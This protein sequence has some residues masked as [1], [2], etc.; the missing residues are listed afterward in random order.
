MRVP[1]SV[2]NMATVA[3]SIKRPCSTTPGIEL[4]TRDRTSG[5]G[6]LPECTVENEVSTVRQKWPSAL[7]CAE[8]DV[9]VTTG[10]TR[11]SRDLARRGRGSERNH[12]NRKCETAPAVSTSLLS[13]AI[14][15]M[16]LELDATIFS[17]K[18]APPPPLIRRREA[19]SSSAPSTVTSRTGVSSSVVSG[20]PRERASLLGCLRCRHADHLKPFGHAR[21]QSAR[22]SGRLWTRFP[23]PAS[24]RVRCNRAPFRRR[25][26]FDRLLT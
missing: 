25:G 2:P 12:L 17:R 20:M 3:S 11:R 21:A 18:S 26:V 24:C 10:F 22:E 5:S 19:S 13:S 4:K 16:R 1:S 7:A 8:N 9:A 14:T 6:N 23:A 15:I